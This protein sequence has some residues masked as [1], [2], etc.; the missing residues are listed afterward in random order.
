MNSALVL[1]LLLFASCFAQDLNASA[2]EGD[3]ELQHELE[4]AV[5][6]FHNL[7][8]L[9]DEIIDVNGDLLQNAM[10]HDDTARI[11][12]KIKRKEA[13]ILRSTMRSIERLLKRQLEGRN[14]QQQLDMLNDMKL[15]QNDIRIFQAAGMNTKGIDLI[16]PNCNKKICILEICENKGTVQETCH[17]FIEGIGCESP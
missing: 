7:E 16:D 1:A 11:K 17:C 2:E 8:E 10:R 12:R 13:H 9:N 15:V 14:L 5:K 4:D 3:H 6:R